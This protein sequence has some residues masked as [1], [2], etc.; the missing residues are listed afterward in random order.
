LRCGS[1]QSDDGQTFKGQIQYS[2]RIDDINL[3]SEEITLLSVSL[4][5][6]KA[7][8]DGTATN[9]KD[10]GFTFRIIVVDDGE[11]GDT[12]FF[13]ITIRDSLDDIVYQNEG[14]LSKGNIEV[15]KQ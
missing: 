2:D 12:D 4:S 11:P 3:H 7:V 5:G 15:Q 13:S 6:T 1:I 8:F 9:N 14:L 10:P